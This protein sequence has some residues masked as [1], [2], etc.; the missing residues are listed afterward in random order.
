M[1]TRDVILAM[2]DK[3]GESTAVQIGSW[4]G[5]SA[6][7]AHNALQYLVRDGMAVCRKEGRYAFWS[8]CEPDLP[9]QQ[10]WIGYQPSEVKHTHPLMNC[11]Y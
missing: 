11:W 3:H 7:A 8:I 4:V 9:I 2:L 1:K 6:G 10:S 5:I